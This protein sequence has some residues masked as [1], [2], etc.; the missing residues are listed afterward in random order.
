MPVDKLEFVKS[1]KKRRRKRGR[2]RTGHD[3]MVGVRLAAPVIRK[4]DKMAAG[5]D[6]DR[7]TI[8][9]L[10]VEHI[11]EYGRP[12]VQTIRSLLIQ[13]LRG[14]RGRGRAADKIAMATLENVKALA[15]KYLRMRRARKSKD[16]V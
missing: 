10:C 1:K 6:C 8:L 15:A 16:L 5:I 13:S 2:P 4:V 9:R 7:A 11:L 14:W 12:E 3:P